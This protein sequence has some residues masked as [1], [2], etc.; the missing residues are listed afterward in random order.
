MTQK[1]DFR[2]FHRLRVRWAEVDLQRVVFNGHYLLYFDTAMADY[3]RALA[4]PYHDA[5]KKLG[6]DLYVRKSTL[7]HLASAGYDDQLDVALRCQR[8]GTSSMV[9]A[10]AIW[11]GEKLLVTTE[12]V[13]VFADPA[14]QTAKPIPDA[15]RAILI[16]YEAGETPFEVRLGG[17][18][19]LGEGAAAVRSEVFLQEQQIPVEM[20]WDE[21][22]QTCLHALATNRLGMP[23]ATGRLL[24]H[25]PGVARIG[26]MAVRA[27]L[28]GSRVGAAVLDALVNAARQRGDHEVLLHAQM[29]AAGFYRRAGFVERGA[30]FEEAGIG[31][32]EMVRGL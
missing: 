25:A 9:V 13:Y 11:R 30:P 7:E 3:W 31:H 16:T 20:E 5:M 18:A 12:L 28:R 19:E 15:L 26:R 10:G 2:F 8:I 21:A 24:Q 32:V 23:L 1:S 22:D 29:S 4:L 17:W 27:Q 14:T 6:G